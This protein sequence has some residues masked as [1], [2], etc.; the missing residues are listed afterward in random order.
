MGALASRWAGP[1]ISRRTAFVLSQ[2]L[3][4]HVVP[5]HSVGALVI[6]VDIVLLEQSVHD[7]QMDGLVRTAALQAPGL[8]VWWSTRQAALS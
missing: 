5:A 7:V 1:P 8:V 3:T 6:M 2:H 4:A